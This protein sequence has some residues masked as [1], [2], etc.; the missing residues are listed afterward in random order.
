MK[1]DDEIVQNG[2]SWCREFDS[3]PR[4]INMQ[5]FSNIAPQKLLDPVYIFEKTP[6]TDFPFQYLVFIFGFLII[7]AVIFWFIYG[8]PKK[9]IPIYA[10]LQSKVFN[11]FCY[12]GL[13]G[14]VLIFFRWQQIAY[15][16]SRFFMLLLLLIFIIWGIY[17]IYFRLKIVPKEIKKYQEKK[18]F[19]KYL[20]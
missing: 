7:L 18:Q 17:I 1:W 13:I 5:I 11:L 4:H 15:L 9:R 2:K 16:G 6:P 19:E 10:K 20:P 8:R 12:T 3:L 14:L